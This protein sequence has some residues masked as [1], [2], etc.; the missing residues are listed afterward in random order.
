MFLISSCFLIFER[1]AEHLGQAE[2]LT[3][4]VLYLF[5]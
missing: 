2:H 4:S 1:R 5:S 3:Q